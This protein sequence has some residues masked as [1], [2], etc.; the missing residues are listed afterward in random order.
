MG[1]K[2]HLTLY[3][4]ILVAVDLCDHE[5]CMCGEIVDKTGG[6]QTSSVVV[7]GADVP[8]DSPPDPEKERKRKELMGY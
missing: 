1:S 3:Q 4:K 6:T 5:V 2:N 8:A 7:I